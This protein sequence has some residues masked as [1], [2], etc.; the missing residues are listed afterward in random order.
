MLK[1]SLL[2]FPITCMQS[3]NVTTAVHEEFLSA[4]S[5]DASS[6]V[7]RPGGPMHGIMK[8]AIVALATLLPSSSLASAQEPSPQDPQTVAAADEK[9]KAAPLTVEPVKVEPVTVKPVQVE[10][11]SVQPLKVDMK[12][13][14]EDGTKREIAEIRVKAD[15]HAKVLE[16]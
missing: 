13:D 5:S 11:V 6:R 3:Q 9:P 1:V 8:A 16:R 4:G 10:P 15:E 2:H 14:F 7:S 12:I